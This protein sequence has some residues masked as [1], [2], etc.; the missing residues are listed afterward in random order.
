[1]ILVVEDHELY[2][3]A[4]GKLL[5]TAG[6][7]VTLLGSGEAALAF[8]SQNRPEI[9]ILDV[10]LPGISGLE[11]LRSLRGRKE[12]CDI[13]VIVSTS[14]PDPRIESQAVSAGATFISKGSQQLQN[15]PSV[16]AQ[17]LRTG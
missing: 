6:H 5:E 4:V 12:L 7:E 11:L 9:I 16:V 3:Q 10:D 2:G 1:M 13:P 15:L 17:C 14:S 8:L